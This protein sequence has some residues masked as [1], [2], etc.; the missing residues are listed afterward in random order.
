[1]KW[2]IKIVYGKRFY[3]SISVQVSD[4]TM[5]GKEPVPVKKNRQ[6]QAYFVGLRLFIFKKVIY[7]TQQYLFITVQRN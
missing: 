6:I 4:T 5:I 2:D 7:A 1:M 3:G